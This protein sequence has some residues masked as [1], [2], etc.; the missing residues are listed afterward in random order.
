MIFTLEF[1]DYT[2]PNQ[3]F[4]VDTSA[5]INS[6]KEENIVRQ[7]GA[8]VQTPFLKAKRFKVKGIIHNT[9][10]AAS[11]SELDDMQQN[12]LADKN[13]FRDRA[14]REIEAYVKKVTA[15]PELGSDKA[16]LNLVIDM[17][18][19]IPF[20]TTVG[21]SVETAFTLLDGVCLFDLAVGGNAFAEPKIYIHANG[22]TIN[23]D[24]QLFNITNQ[25]QLFK[26]RGTIV[27]GE[28]V[29]IDTKELTVLNDGVDGIS[30]FEGDF[31]NL[32]AGTN[33][34]SF[35]GS[36]C[37]LTFERKNRWY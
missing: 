20:F 15:K 12:L 10:N 1:G 7:H 4:E 3:T 30:D 34:F 36:T 18:A 22:G 28:T 24:F 5:S 29:V 8:V 2:F 35:A 31:L 27:D 9:T 13:S 33:E 26:F 32:L 14:D 11:L 17:V 23:D 37:L 16:I 6:V 25:N 19:P 21:A